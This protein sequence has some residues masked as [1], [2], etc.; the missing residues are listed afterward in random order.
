MTANSLSGNS[1]PAAPAARSGRPGSGSKWQALLAVGLLGVLLAGCVPEKQAPKVSVAD[2][3]SNAA[4]DSAAISASGNATVR[5]TQ[6][7]RAQAGSAPAATRNDDVNAVGHGYFHQA[8]LPAVD[9]RPARFLGLQDA[10]LRRLL[11][12]PDL[13]R[14]EAQAQVWQYQQDSCVLD[15]YLYPQ[16]G[17]N[18]VVY[19]E[20]RDQEAESLPA[21][22]CLTPLLAAKQAG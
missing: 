21:V 14:R 11:G 10:E 8:S 5:T 19:I 13:L 22:R 4:L 7:T 2:L 18:L 12:D 15:V 16:D 3:S 1:E 6:G 17:E 9:A 20:A